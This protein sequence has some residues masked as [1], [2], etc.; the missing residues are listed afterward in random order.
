MLIK[1]LNKMCQ[2]IRDK[3]QS[4]KKVV[5]Y[6]FEE[7]GLALNKILR[8]TSFEL[9]KI[10]IAE[11]RKRVFSC[12]LLGVSPLKNRIRKILFGND[13]L[14]NTSDSI[15]FNYYIQP[16]EYNIKF[17]GKIVCKRCSLW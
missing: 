5:F 8:S 16:E 7:C 4:F 12:F 10:R 13:I 2:I 17:N 11:E 14:L 15:Y 1:N 3:L 9:I 6:N